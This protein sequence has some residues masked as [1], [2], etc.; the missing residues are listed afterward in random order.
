MRPLKQARL[1]TATDPGV[2]DAPDILTRKV[3]PLAIMGQEM[4][5]GCGSITTA[6][7]RG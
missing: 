3:G 6:G 7:L 5:A 2:A 1:C 4:R